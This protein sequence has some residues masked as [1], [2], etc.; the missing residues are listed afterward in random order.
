[1]FLFLEVLAVMQG[2]EVDLLARSWVSPSNEAKVLWLF[3]EK[4]TKIGVSVCIQSLMR[5]IVL[6]LHVA[7]RID[8]VQMPLHL[9]GRG[10]RSIHLVVFVALIN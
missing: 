9:L 10:H 6:R 4:G 3:L 2:D 7:Q 5:T 8:H 1:M